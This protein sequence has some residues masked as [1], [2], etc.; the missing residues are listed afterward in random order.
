VAALA[1]L[2]LGEGITRLALPAPRINFYWVFDPDIGH[3][4]KPDLRA[5]IG[6]GGE[7]HEFRINGDGFRDDP[8]LTEKAPGV[9]RIALLG[10]SFCE[11]LS[12][13]LEKTFF[14]LLA[15]DL[16]S[17][18][19]RPVEVLSFGI[20]DTGQ[21]EQWLLLEDWVPRYS[22]DAL[23]AT[24]FPLNDVVNNA[25]DFAGRN[26]SPTDDYRP[27]FTPE[28][29]ELR[30][31]YARPAWGRLRA[32]SRLLTWAEFA[33]L[34]IRF[35]MGRAG[36]LQRYVPNPDRIPNL[37]IGVALGGPDDEAWARAWAVTEALLAEIG[38]SAERKGLPLLFV[39][40]PFKEQVHATL[41]D[42]YVDTVPP[43]PGRSYD[44]ER[45][46]RRITDILEHHGL[47]FVSLLPALRDH[48]RQTGETL[49]FDP[50]G[51]WNPRGHEIVAT[52]LREPVMELLAR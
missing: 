50:D 25:V 7:R 36:W 40:I 23:C 9:L 6:E 24:I 11:A 26:A 37:E 2:L 20:G 31:T 27:Y 47:R 8:H 19:R 38:R 1:T 42:R 22:P 10:D 14:R 21:A 32:T 12:V 13:P 5:E 28:S 39:T 16:E 17:R 52:L 35:R 46:E 41:R 4:L 44:F 49:Y 34:A 33:W 48:A 3:R 45:P 15:R 29:G 43:P 30:R 51:H 18:L